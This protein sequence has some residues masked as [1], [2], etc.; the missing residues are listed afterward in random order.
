MHFKIYVFGYILA[1]LFMSTAKAGNQ[2]T[3]A[4]DL[5]N[6]V[7]HSTNSKAGAET[8]HHTLT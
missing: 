5:S 8:R 3:M 7:Y 1:T 4:V 6:A 2:A